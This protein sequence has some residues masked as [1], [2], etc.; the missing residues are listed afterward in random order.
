[1]PNATTK[2]EFNRM[3]DDLACVEG[4]LVSTIMPPLVLSSP[5]CDE[6]LHMQ[7]E[8][9]LVPLHPGFSKEDRDCPF[10]KA[11]DRGIKVVLMIKGLCG[12]VVEWVHRYGHA[13][14]T[15]YSV[16]TILSEAGTL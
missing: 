15:Y 14:W 10:V 3:P 13:Q 2:V 7:K 12:K 9:K 5:S 11:P 16:D 1:M 8:D 6:L 4:W